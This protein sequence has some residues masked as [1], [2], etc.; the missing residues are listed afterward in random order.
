MSLYDWQIGM[1][2]ECI[3]DAVAKI[4]DLGLPMFRKGQIFTI[5]GIDFHEP[6]GVFLCF[7]ECDPRQYG[8]EVGFR[9]IVSKKTDISVFTAM[10]SKPRVPA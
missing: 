2:V 8:H 1:K 9:P 3:V 4:G 7:E 6:Y 10:L 5:S